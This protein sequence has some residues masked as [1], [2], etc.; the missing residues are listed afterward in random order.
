[1]RNIVPAAGGVGGVR[2]VERAQEWHVELMEPSGRCGP[3]RFCTRSLDINHPLWGLL[4]LLPSTNAIV[5]GEVPIGAM[6]V[7]M[8]KFSIP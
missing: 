7:Y 1:M 8:S 2:E 6:K 5:S 3:R 4:Q